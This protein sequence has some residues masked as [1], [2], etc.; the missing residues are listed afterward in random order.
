[1]LSSEKKKKANLK[2]QMVSPAPVEVASAKEES[3]P[4]SVAVVEEVKVQ[5]EP[6]VA[7]SDVG[8]DEVK[9]HGISNTSDQLGQ[10]IPLA[11]DSRFEDV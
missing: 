8:S 3:Q 5:D 11:D 4:D 7:Q 6:T 1:M 9:A 2:E 10:D